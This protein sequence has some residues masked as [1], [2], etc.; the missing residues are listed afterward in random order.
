[1][2]TYCKLD[3]Y[4]QTSASIQVWKF[5]IMKMHLKTSANYQSFC[6]S[7]NV[8]MECI[9]IFSKICNCNQF[10]CK[11]N[12][13]LQAKLIIDSSYKCLVYYVWHILIVL[14]DR[15]NQLSLVKPCCLN[16]CLHTMILL[17]S[18]CTSQG[19]IHYKPPLFQ[20]MTWC[21]LAPSHQLNQ[22]WLRNLMG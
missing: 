8:L 7:P 10:D 6:L 13:G 16:Q 5:S 3:P 11:L 9:T 19:L 2:L 20:V 1:M 17:W 12:T 15:N 18:I 21:H 4:E 22:W 14:L